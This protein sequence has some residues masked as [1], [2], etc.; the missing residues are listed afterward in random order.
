MEFVAPQTYI[1]APQTPFFIFCFL[2]VVLPT[3][4]NFHESPDPGQ[5]SVGSINVT[6]STDEPE[7][8]II[9]SGYRPT[10]R[11]SRPKTR[12]KIRHLQGPCTGEQPPQNILSTPIIPVMKGMRE[13][14]S[15]GDITKNLQ[16]SIY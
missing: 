10:T 14:V 8:K 3:A 4:C 15:N 1:G 16:K 6:A 9:L 13:V 7:T 2:L 12:Q 5:T 11:H